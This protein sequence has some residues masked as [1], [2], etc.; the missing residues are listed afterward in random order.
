MIWDWVFVGA[1]PA[2]L[3]AANVL[4]DKGETNILIL[5]KGN[6]L[7]RRG[8]PGR[9]SNTCAGCSGGTCHVEAG[10]GGSSAI[11]G[12]KL[13][14][15]PAS[16]GIQDFF[17]DETIGIASEYLNVLLSPIFRSGRLQDDRRLDQNR[18]QYNAD[19]ILRS[20][21]RRLIEKLLYRPRENSVIRTNAGVADVEM[22]EGSGFGL[23]LKN[24]GRIFAKRLILGCGR[25][26]HEFTRSVMDKLG[27]RLAESTPDVGFRIEAPDRILNNSFFYQN[28]PKYKFKHALGGTSRTF[29]TCR[30]GAI[31]PVQL[32]NS[33]FA[34]G[35]FLDEVTGRTNVAFMARSKSPIS[36][37]DLEAWCTMVNNQAS[38]R[39]LLGE[40]QL[41]GIA[42]NRC[43]NKIVDLIKEWP[44]DDH[45]QILVDLL[46][47]TLFGKH[48]LIDFNASAEQAVRVFGPSIDQYWPSP[49]LTDGLGTGIKDLS[50]LG[51]ANGVSRGVVQALVSG[52]SWAVLQN[53][54]SK[55]HV[56][57]SKLVKPLS[58][59]AA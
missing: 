57:A 47:H 14:Y 27:V 53:T 49:L 21:Y 52:A 5:D 44:N 48:P 45:Y 9:R 31:I 36:A 33:V 38:G 40:V 23:I 6:P 10:E 55:R 22:L 34:D 25:S 41:G 26:G 12:N 16:S 35:A 46:R 18:K 24:S 13:C 43:A 37:R 28:D 29:C 56:S 54:T 42:Q 8:C 11:F 20:D 15:F 17:S 50:I 2:N 58:L 39:L 7:H 32:N 4:L 3:A 59:G 51:D 30:G 19:I 1:G